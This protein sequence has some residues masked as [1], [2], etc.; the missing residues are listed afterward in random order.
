[1]SILVY[2]KR[3]YEYY[4]NS[5]YKSTFSFIVLIFLNFTQG[6]IPKLSSFLRGKE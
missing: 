1:M 2:K 3:K 4:T 5:V 6:M